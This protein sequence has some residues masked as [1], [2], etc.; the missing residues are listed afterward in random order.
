MIP[1]ELAVDHTSHL[2]KLMRDRSRVHWQAITDIIEFFF[3]EVQEDPETTEILA[4][5]RKGKK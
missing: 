5:G 2:E 1:E 4:Q 3:K